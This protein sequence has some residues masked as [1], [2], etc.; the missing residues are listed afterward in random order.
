MGDRAEQ[1]VGV[2]LVARPTFEYRAHFFRRGDANN[3]GHVN[4]SDAIFILRYAFGRGDAPTCADSADAN[5][6]GV[7]N[8]DD[9]LTLLEALFESGGPLPLPLS[10][11]CGL[12]PTEDELGCGGQPACMSWLEE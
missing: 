7:L 12:D 1:C 6:D 2:S 4:I 9:V 3:D 11:L 10:L 8:T 5:D